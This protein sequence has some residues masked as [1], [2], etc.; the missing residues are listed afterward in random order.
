MSVSYEVFLKSDRI[1]YLPNDTVIFNVFVKNNS[2]VIIRITNFVL[3]FEDGSNTP[4]C[5]LDF[6]LYPEINKIFSDNSVIKLDNHY[7][8]RQ[9]S[10]CYNIYLLNDEWTLYEK[11][12]SKQY[13]FFNVITKREISSGRFVIFL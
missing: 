10:L 7:G 3:K 8:S 5:N 13:Y 4:L 1:F 11:Y 12:E 9:F 6:I 2:N